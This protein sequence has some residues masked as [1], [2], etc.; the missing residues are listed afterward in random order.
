[1]V[2]MRWR[3]FTMLW[4]VLSAWA[5]H[6]PASSA[7]DRFNMR[8]ETPHVMVVADDSGSWGGT[9]M[10]TTHQE[11]PDY[12]ARKRI[13]TAC[14]PAE[15]WASAR[16]TRLRVYFF[17]QDI[18]HWGASPN[19]MDESFEVVVNG[20]THTYHTSDGFP[21]KPTARERLKWEWVDFV[22]PKAELNH[23]D[24]EIIFRKAPAPGGKNDD[25]IYIGIDNS[26]RHGNSSM[27]EDGGN[28]WQENKLNMI[29]ATG[30]YMVRLV[31]IE[32]PGVAQTVSL[33]R[34]ETIATGGKAF[35]YA[36]WDTEGHRHLLGLEP[37]FFSRR[38]EAVARIPYTG[39]TPAVEWID[40][41]GHAMKAETK[42]AA[43][44]VISSVRIGYDRPARLVLAA[45]AS[46]LVLNPGFEVTTGNRP[47]SWLAGDARGE[48]VPLAV[49]GLAPHSGKQS[50]RLRHAGKAYSWAKVYLT[51]KPH[52]RYTA[53]AWI[54]TDGVEAA[55]DGSGARMV[56]A[57]ERG[58]SVMAGAVP[59]TGSAN[60][61]RYTTTFDTGDLN[62]V[63]LILYLHNASGTAW[64]DD[65][66][67]TEGDTPI[68]APEPNALLPQIDSVSIEYAPSYL[69]RLNTEM[70]PAVS[71]PAGKIIARP[72]TCQIAPDRIRLSNSHLTCK[73]GTRGLLRIEELQIHAAGANVVKRRDESFI[74]MVEVGGKQYPAR[75]FTVRKV[76]PLSGDRRGAVI[77]LFLA[78]HSL[79]AKLTV[80]IDAEPELHLSLT[81]TNEGKGDVSFK[82]AFPHLGGL[83]VSDK[84]EDDYYLFPFRGGVI[85]ASPVQLRS[86]Y[87][88]YTCWWQMIDV[89]SPRR[90]AGLYV[91]CADTQGMF[92]FM[93]MSKGR[94]AA[95]AHNDMAGGVDPAMHLGKSFTPSDC[96]AMAV[97]YLQRTRKPGESFA[98]PDAAI[99]VHEGDWH[100]AM[101]RYSDWAHQVW[102]WRPFPSRMHDV[103][104]ITAPGWGK[105]G[106]LFKEGKFIDDF[107]TKRFD[108]AELMSFWNWADAAMWN[109][110][111]DEMKEK[112][113]N[114]LEGM[115]STYIARN[116]VTGKT[117]FMQNW[118]D[119]DYNASFGGLPALRK[120]IADVKAYGMM[121][122]FYVAGYLACATT[123]AGQK[124]GLD[125]GIMP[126][127]T[128]PS[129]S[130]A[131]KGYL[132]SY[133]VFN[134][135]PDNETW[136]DYI[137]QTLRRLAADTA[138]EGV[139]LD[140]FGWAK[141]ACF[142]PRHRH[143]FA[144]PGHNE[145]M[146]AQVNIYSKI[147]EA[148]D[149]VDPMFSM[150]A[151]H[152]GYDCMAR[153]MDWALDYDVRNNPDAVRKV[154]FTLFRFYFPECK[155][156]EYNDGNPMMPEYRLFNAWA[157]MH[158]NDPELYHITLL[159]NGDAFDSRDVEP[160]VRTLRRDVYSHRF[161][162]RGKAIYTFF[163]AAGETVKGGVLPT[164]PAAGKHWVDLLT[165]EELKL[166]SVGK[167]TAVALAIPDQKAAC[168]A[169]LPELLKVKRIDET[170]LAEIAAA[171][172]DTFLILSDPAGNELFRATAVKGKIEIPLAAL[173]LMKNCPYTVK[174][175]QGKYL[176]D[177][178]GFEF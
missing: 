11:R 30:E 136:S 42:L 47:V 56:I 166:T 64:F 74:F 90:G 10:G 2:V 106:M 176:R 172:P 9:G 158:P 46:G 36:A 28:T 53:S 58:G 68:D 29:N 109:V 120:Y 67:F 17:T 61:S 157:V 160:L 33:K 134:M 103:W 77:D 57:R 49:D 88:G 23:G 27:S 54:R 123:R 169:R 19:G 175:L 83:A 12:Q 118:G 167:Q 177:M 99:G 108:F 128:S 79:G 130:V 69:P 71:P 100:A 40:E 149:P 126:L 117:Q 155:T 119:Y 141:P 38:S 4:V 137:A 78:E 86:S 66:T 170:L 97:E 37:S 34:G 41:A 171:N 159:E 65:V 22:L 72:P 62:E 8:S 63:N 112:F 14:V 85:N 35:S 18:S 165:G 70:T 147:R 76:M 91:R 92:K 16:E 3:N 39:D 129:S 48:F 115:M 84:P 152:Y 5:L 107:M 24:N 94:D 154:P 140:E 105:T 59:V 124:Y 133:G 168:I 32:E 163:N 93:S 174:L 50:L 25:Y 20:H 162:A 55:P 101:K 95:F 6:A 89:Y 114:R 143:I 146:R 51:V 135:C 80:S 125:Y 81:V 26:V 75:S 153:Y 104:N 142:S 52:S 7:D 148:V 156:A 44:A 138:I 121:P 21:A 98:L 1:M 145:N 96:T 150:A 132:D 131:P 102:K 87:G 45:P 43:A 113:S 161:S 82:T 151:E 111:F 110:P 139:R 60:W 178:T 116:P 15:K 31:L 122:T 164:E 144:E 127:S 73:L 173:K 13:S